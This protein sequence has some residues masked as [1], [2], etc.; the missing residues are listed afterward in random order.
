MNKMKKKLCLFLLFLC[1]WPALPVAAP[2]ASAETAPRTWYEVFVGSYC[3][4]DGDGVGDLGGLTGKLDYIAGMGFDGIWLTPVFPS[5]TYH[6]YDA[7]DYLSID[8][9]FGTMDDF[10]AFVAGCDARGIAVLLDL[11]INHTSSGHPWFLAALEALR[12]GDTD[13]PYVSYYHFERRAAG[14]AWA[15]AGGGW[16]YEAQFWDGMP[17]LNLENPAVRAELE[18]VM[19]FWL[20]KGVAGFRLDAV[21]E[22]ATGSAAANIAILQWIAQTAKAVNPDVYLVGE[23]WDTTDGLYAYYRGIG[24]LFAFPFAAQD[25]IIAKTLIQGKG[26]DAAGFVD[27]MAH[28]DA[29]IMASG[30]SPAGAAP[31][32]TN[33]DTAR[34]AGF[35]RRDTA[36]IKT[37]WG[38]LL[39][40]TGNAFVYYGEE[41]GMAGSGSDEN[42]RAPMR[43]TE[44][45]DAPGMTD[46]PAGMEPQ[47]QSFAPADEQAED[48]DSIYTYLKDAIR[49]RREIPAIANG[50]TRRIANSAEP[51]VGIAE[52]V[53]EGRRAVIVYNLSAQPQTANLLGEPDTLPGTLAGC[54]SAEGGTPAFTDTAVTLPPYT[55]AVFTD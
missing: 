54:L 16:A 3:D 23:D 21:K 42:K 46:G 32:L 8:P 35:L 17:D 40:M 25:G 9:Q 47:T 44:D 52:R 20:D 1:L 19:R 24:S 10:D 2:P 55:I 34:A 53:W 49:L 51:V 43:W 48:P 15:D 12:A 33:H 45:G 37:A 6:K 27:A 29:Q 14:G 13:S 22:Y 36:K 39:T 4:S 28:A 31:F 50:T 41:I 7:T 5:P 30:G 26:M 11:A 38:M 18:A